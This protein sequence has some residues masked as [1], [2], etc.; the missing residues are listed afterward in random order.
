LP[1]FIL[2]F[3]DSG[4]FDMPSNLTSRS[5][6]FGGLSGASLQG[7]TLLPLSCL[8]L[9]HFSSYATTDGN[10]PMDSMPRESREPGLDILVK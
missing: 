6:M 3:N 1:G 5:S 9:V 4:G 7:L 10:I 2:N 8:S